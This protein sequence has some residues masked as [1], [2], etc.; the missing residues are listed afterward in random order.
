MYEMIVGIIADHFEA[1]V[2][3]VTRDTDI[4][5]DLKADSLDFF[6]MIMEVENKLGHRVNLE[7]LE[8]IKTVGEFADYLESHENG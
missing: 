8:N 1:D 6:E 7:S 5:K 3:T 4:I 2:E